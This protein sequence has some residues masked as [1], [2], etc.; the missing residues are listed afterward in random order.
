MC[1][2]WWNT[3]LQKQYTVVK[4][5]KNTSEK[6]IRVLRHNTMGKNL[7][8]RQ[9]AGEPEVYNKLLGLTHPNLPRIYQVWRHEQQTALL[10]EW[11]DGVT[12]FD[13][14]ESGL[15]VEDGVR[16][17]ASALCDALM[18]LQQND[19]IH[20]D[21]KPENV[22]VDAEGTVKLIDF[23]AARIYKPWQSEDTTV[24]GTMG[25]V[26]PEQLGVK[27]TDFRTDIYALG[28]LMNVMLTGKH[29][30]VAL[31]RGRLAKQIARCTHINPSKRYANAQELK[32]ALR[33]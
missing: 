5:M 15:Y 14:L 16:H 26:A 22:M 24:M 17:V 1:L 10:E 11:I 20:R 2:D 21:I 3:A 28:V 13:V 32:N 9:F 6:Q 31:Y 8:Y 19:I 4:V 18:C 23:D 30:A 7:V 12:V 29:P 33:K 25:Y 27:Q